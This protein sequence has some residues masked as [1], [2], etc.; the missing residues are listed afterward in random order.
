MR[1]SAIKDGVVQDQWLYAILRDEIA[2]PAGGRPWP[3]PG[4]RFPL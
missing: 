1:Q 2:G 4:G 3:S